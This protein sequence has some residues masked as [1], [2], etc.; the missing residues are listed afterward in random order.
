[1]GQQ[2]LLLVVLGVIIV[3]IAIIMGISLFSANAIETKRNMLTNELVNL[4]SMAQQHYRK[5]NA[6]G[7]GNY[8]FDATNGGVAWSIPP[9][10]TNTGHGRFE[11]SEIS[12]K[13][14]VIVGTGNEVTTA[15]DTV[16]VQITVNPD[17]YLVTII[18]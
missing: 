5:P 15:N 14:L 12:S 8:A 4:A 3:G 10:L 16:S 9:N 7:G 11:I 1:M 13:S 17:D 18:N 6:M 2:Q